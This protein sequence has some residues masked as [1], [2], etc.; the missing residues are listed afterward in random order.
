MVLKGE[1]AA[2]VNDR[3]EKLA[4]GPQKVAVLGQ[5]HFWSH[6]VEGWASDVTSPT[7]S[8]GYV[9]WVVDL[10]EQWREL[11]ALPGKMAVKTH[12]TVHLIT[13][14]HTSSC[15]SWTPD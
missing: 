15:C 10:P 9:F 14:F 7:V 3:G 8:S 13:G 11:C 4:E 2:R 6:L 5:N 12:N 1:P